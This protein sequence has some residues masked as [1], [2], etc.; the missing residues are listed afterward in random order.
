MSVDM[1]DEEDPFA[2]LDDL[3][4]NE[5]VV[6]GANA[7]GGGGDANNDDPAFVGEEFDVGP[8]FIRRQ[9]DEE[10]IWRRRVEGWVGG[11]RDSGEPH[12]GWRWAIRELAAH[13]AA[14]TLTT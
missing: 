7:A 13:A 10:A 8:S 12:G 11:L 6:G 4:D 3:K 5:S 9:R 14:E 2:G 1:E